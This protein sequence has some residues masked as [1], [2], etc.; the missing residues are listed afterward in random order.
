MTGTLVLKH[1]PEDF[2]VRENLVLALTDEAAADQRYLLLHKRGY[3]TMEAVRLVADR[4]G[5]P[6]R[7]VGYAGLK[8]EDG[9]TEQL[10]SVPLKAPAALGELT[11]AGLVEERGP[12]RL[13]SLSHYGYGRE[14]LRVGRLNGN[15]FRVVL[16]GLDETTA[17]HLAD[18]HRMNLL[19]V[20]YYDTQRF[21]VP[22]G[23]KRTHLVGEALLKE[24]W[25]LARRELAGLG[26]P[27]SGIAE[28]WDGTDQD[29]F[30]ELD[31]RT[32]AFYLAAHSSYE[33]NAQVR[34]LVATNC[35][36]ESAETRVDG[37][38]YRFPTTGRAVAA[39]LAA[40]HELPYMRYAYQ[41]GP[42]ERP[43]VRPTVIQTTVTAEEEGPDEEFPGRRAVEVSFLL[44]SGCYATAALRQLIAQ[45]SEP[46]S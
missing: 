25:A 8:D 45:C 12:D 38:P 43:T 35:P 33:W 26:A 16:R 40:C 20:N 37:L 15:G 30:R 13:L 34:E 14:P 28:R 6:S 31:P 11:S 17:A 41:D 10:L 18:R 5:V 3:T 7:D 1:R 4:L 29:L 9:I 24:D 27:E 44:P 22:G 32:V 36:E 21:G 46:V 42:V 19:F 23:P 39:L 2:R